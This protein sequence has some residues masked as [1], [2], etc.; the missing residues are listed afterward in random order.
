L[1]IIEINNNSIPLQEF[2]HPDNA[3]YLLGS[4][5]PSRKIPN[6]LL[7]KYPVIEIPKYWGLPKIQKGC[8]CLNVSVA[9]SIV[10][11]DRLIKK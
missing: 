6:E 5:N 3:V 4:E 1:I 8:F 9:G 7:D 11:Y 10:L 2:S